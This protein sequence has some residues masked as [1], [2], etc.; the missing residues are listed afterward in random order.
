VEFW[1]LQAVTASRLFLATPL[2]LWVWWKNPRG[3]VLWKC[4]LLAWYVATDKWDGPFAREH[5]YDT[6]FGYWLDHVGDFAFWL[7]VVFTL[8]KGAREPALRK[9]D[10]ARARARRAAAGGQAPPPERPPAVPAAT[11]PPPPDAQAGASPPTTP[12]P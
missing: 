11:E 9:P 6:E 8:Y 2:W 1:I 7:A 10:A 4:L 3:A 5:G 12:P